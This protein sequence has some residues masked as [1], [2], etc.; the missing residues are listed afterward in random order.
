MGDF[1]LLAAG[2]CTRYITLKIRSQGLP[3]IVAVGSFGMVRAENAWLH[4][5]DWV[6]VACYR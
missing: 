5:F 2:A 1:A 6:R 3:C 4:V